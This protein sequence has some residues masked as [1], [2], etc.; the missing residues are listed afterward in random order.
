MSKGQIT[1]INQLIILLII[2]CASG[3][4]IAGLIFTDS[5]ESGDLSH[6]QGKAAWFNPTKV[7][8][9]SDISHSGNHSLK[10]TYAGVP[11]GKDSF[12]ELRYDLG[13]AYPDVWIQFYIYFPDGTESPNV[14]PKYVHRNDTGPDNNKFLRIWGSSPDGR[15]RN[16]GVTV[17]GGCSLLPISGGYSE[18]IPEWSV[19]YNGK[20]TSAMGSH[21]TPGFWFAYPETLGKWIK[22]KFHRKVASPANNDG[23]LQIW[24]NDV[25]SIDLQNLNT[26]P[27]DGYLNAFTAGY[28][29]G[30]SNSG[31]DKE[32][33]IYIDDVAI[34]TT[35][36]FNTIEASTPKQPIAAPEPPGDIK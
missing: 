30:W 5:F 2:S 12:S 36:D 11:S 27:G 28:L 14:G 32:T 6:T 8:V 33:Y 3:T 21:S 22:F 26:Y 20:V 35:N 25:L 16:S 19:T 29:L 24:E 23:I 17:N 34:S 18:M 13:A 7:N 1:A 9:T 15:N 10:Y 4:S 31:F